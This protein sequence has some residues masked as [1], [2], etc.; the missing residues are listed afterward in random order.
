MSTPKIDASSRLVD[1][2]AEVANPDGKLKPGQFLQVRVLLPKEDGVIA[3]PQ[4][5]LVS[6]LYGDY[7]Y[8]VK[9]APKTEGADASGGKASDT[10]AS[11]TKAG[12]AKAADDKAGPD[13]VA[14]Q[15]F[16]TVG[17][18]SGEVV[19]IVKGLKAGDQIVTAGQNRL[20]NNSPVTVDNTITPPA[21]PNPAD[22]K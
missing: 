4:T 17:R 9:P 20:S 18:H 19:E 11:D 3:V 13:L 14:A 10:K 12:D 5:A 15:V 21:N 16:V 1:V 7:V 22:V 8:V 6:S 2:R